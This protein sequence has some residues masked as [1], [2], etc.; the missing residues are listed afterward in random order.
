MNSLLLA[1]LSD[2]A[3]LKQRFPTTAHLSDVAMLRTSAWR[4]ELFA[5][6]QHD[7]AELTRARG[8]LTLLGTAIMVSET[9]LVRHLIDAG[10]DLNAPAATNGR[11]GVPVALGLWV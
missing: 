8:D 1:A 11:L 9:D 4:R 3:A 10:A 5:A 2:D 6:I 7:K